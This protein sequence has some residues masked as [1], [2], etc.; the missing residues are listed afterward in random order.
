M[1]GR[2]E[3]DLVYADPEVNLR[4]DQAGTIPVYIR[5]CNGTRIEKY[6]GTD[7]DAI[8]I[9]PVEPVNLPQEITHHLEIAFPTLVLPPA[10]QK[11]IY[12]KFPV[13]I[14]VFFEFRHEMSVL[15]IFSLVPTKFSLYG[16]PSNGVITR[17]YQSALFHKIPETELH[18]EGALELSLVNHCTETVE[19]TRAVFDS[20]HMNLFYGDRVG[21]TGT[22][23]ILSP[24]IA[25]TTFAPTAPAGCPN[26]SIDL[27]TSRK[28]AVGPGK[29]YM[30]E[31]GMA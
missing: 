12:L 21:M 28:F 10:A 24:L 17:W 6:L 1:F 26:K 27:Y 8:H 22:M 15:D 5:E 23:E 20:H 19:V 11:T 14:G 2:Y 9:C 29:G 3:R 16:P 13:E 7:Y 31:S 30:M 18:R 4:I 25:L